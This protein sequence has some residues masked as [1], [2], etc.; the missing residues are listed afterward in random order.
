MI[1]NTAAN[2][3]A[4]ETDRRWQHRRSTIPATARLLLIAQP[5]AWLPAEPNK[6]SPSYL[7]N[8]GVCKLFNFI[9]TLCRMATLAA[10]KYVTLSSLLTSKFKGRFGRE[11][12][13]CKVVD[14][15][16]RRPEAFRIPWK[17]LKQLLLCQTGQQ[18]VWIGL[19]SLPSSATNSVTRLIC[20]LNSFYNLNF[21]AFNLSPLEVSP[22][23]A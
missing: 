8:L 13:C 6:L 19:W 20:Y 14:N 5:A 2:E 16:L 9:D 21:I 4:L 11:A 10:A 18:A 3:C 22:S 15:Y 12:D 1:R 17:P 23:F 7:I